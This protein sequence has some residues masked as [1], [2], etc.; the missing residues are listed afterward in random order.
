MKQIFLVLM[1]LMSMISLIIEKSE[2]YQII[3]VG[4]LF[5]ILMELEKII[6]KKN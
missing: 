6:K 4:V 5:L 1:V 2:T 3:V